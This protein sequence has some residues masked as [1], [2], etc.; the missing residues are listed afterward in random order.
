MSV[1]TKQQLL[2]AS[3]DAINLGLALNSDEETFL[4]RYGQ[5]RLTLVGALIRLGYSAPV[6]YA[7][8]IS[9]TAGTQ[10]VEYGGVVYAPLLAEL[11][12]TTSGTFETAKFRVLQGIP[13]ADW[14]TKLQRVV[15]S[16]SDLKALD[17]TLYKRAFVLG[18][19]ADGDGGGGSYYLDSGDTTTADN[20]GTVIV[21]SDGGR[22]KYKDY[23]R[24][25]VHA[26]LFGVLSSGTAAN[27][28]TNLQKAIDFLYALGGGSISFGPYTYQ[29]NAKAQLKAKVKLKG[30]Y[31]TILLGTTAEAGIEIGSSHIAASVVAMQIVGHHDGAGVYAGHLIRCYASG[32]RFYDLSF[33]FTTLSA[34]KIEPGTYVVR[35]KRCFGQNLVYSRAALSAPLGGLHVDGADH[36]IDQV[37]FNCASGRTT[38]ESSDAYACSIYIN[39][40]NHY[41]TGLMGEFGE[42]GVYVA[43]TKSRFSVSRADRCM[44]HGWVVTGDNNTF[45]ACQSMENGR[46]AA[47]TYDGLRVTGRMNVFTGFT[48]PFLGT[49]NLRYG[50]IDT[51]ANSTQK[52]QFIGCEVQEG[53]G[54][55]RYFNGN[56]GGGFV[57]CSGPA[58]V[59]S[60]T[61]VDVAGREFV[62]LQYSSDTTVSSVTGAVNGQRIRFLPTD[63][64][65]T[66]A[67][68]ADIKTRTGAN[69]VLTNNLVHEFTFWNG[70]LYQHS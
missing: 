3:L 37:E 46:G 11:P 16:I 5:E 4:T 1:I 38:V 32:C 48:I 15:S 12:F 34:L 22:W 23:R 67:H 27:N 61:T 14:L 7:S 10:T 13:P 58:R 47:N 36:Y 55:A 25:K 39:G 65:V 45:A 30:D 54:T 51:V 35:I 56:Q 62:W 44:G 20:G 26:E 57:F 9:L 63:S 33:D 64:A 19:Y 40:A 29:L 69:L 49:I 70:V 59:A 18:Y 28:S 53:C 68:N 52:N 2:D 21:A 43:C 24:G 60:G 41:V 6:A 66:F 17:K 42:T 8:G 31:A 50:I